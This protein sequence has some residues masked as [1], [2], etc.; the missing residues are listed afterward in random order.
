MKRILILLTLLLPLAAGA[1]RYTI[2]GTVT[3]AKSGETL[4]GAT[5]IDAK[6]GKG[7]VTNPYGRYSLTL[8][9]GDVDI[10]VQYVGY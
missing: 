9:K 7:A 3:D 2:S 6:S 8:Q 4:I 5:I 10:K 1:Q